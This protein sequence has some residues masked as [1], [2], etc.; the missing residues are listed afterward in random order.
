MS[1]AELPSL[2]G[3]WIRFA[4][5]LRAA[6]AVVSLALGSP[7]PRYYE[8]LR[9]PFVATSQVIDS[10]SG[11][12]ALPGA[13]IGL[14]GS[15][16]IFRRALPSLPP[17]GSADAAVRCFSADGRLRPFREIGHHHLRN[18]AEAGSQ[19]DVRAYF[20]DS[21]AVNKALRSLIALVSSVP[22]QSKKRGSV[23]LKHEVSRS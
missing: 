8:S 11:L 9:L 4:H 23:N 12:S 2:H 16:L 7:L 6:N 20:P 19:P 10:L 15:R 14:P 3:H 1:Y 17:D 18:E 13:M 21:D 22:R 5:T